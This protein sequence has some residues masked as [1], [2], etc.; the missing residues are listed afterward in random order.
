[1]N[2]FRAALLA[3]L[4][5]AVGACT[6][7]PDLT[8]FAAC[9]TVGG[10]PTGTAC[11]ASENRCLPMCGEGRPCDLV[12]PDPPDAGPKQDGGAEQ[13]AGLPDGG[14]ADA[15]GDETDAGTPDA[16]PAALALESGV[17]A[18]GIE[19]V[20]YSTRLQARGGMPPYTFNATA[21]L[22]AGF[23]L[24]TDGELTGTPGRAGD[25][26]LPVEVTDVSTPMKR[27][28]GNLLVR[29]RPLLRMAG[30]APLADIPN[31]KAYGERLYATGGKPPYRFT[32][33][34]EQG[35]PSGVTMTSGGVVSGTTTQQGTQ[36]FYVEVA[37]SDTPPQTALRE[38]T[39]TTVAVPGFVKLTSRAAPDGRAGTDYSYTFKT[40]GG[41]GTF[42]WTVKS[43]ELP[44][45]LVLD[46]AQGLLSGTPSTSGTFTFVLGV[47]DL[48]TSDQ[49][50]YSLKVE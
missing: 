29:V 11:L 19:T 6:F 44:P 41:T 23:A 9:D 50:T 39:L 8:R 2:R 13:D 35:L 26:Y 7:A 17:M 49:L 14:T 1:M 12:D 34:T 40:I 42:S 24:S 43:G 16:G 22:P 28:S 37:D 45:G 48:L 31:N 10:C 30:P 47:A 21:V 32:L 15:G 46:S 20:P 18:E 5:V 36:N 4:F 38:L 33:R 3:A 27:A 25:V